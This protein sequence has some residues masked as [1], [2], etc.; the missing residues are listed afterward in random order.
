MSQGANTRI[1]TQCKIP[2]FAYLRSFFAI[3]ALKWPFWGPPGSIWRRGETMDYSN[4]DKLQFFRHLL[5]SRNMEK[6]ISD[7][8]LQMGE[9]LSKLFAEKPVEVQVSRRAES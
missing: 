6:P 4:V 8:V 7:V 5:S 3:F 9:G 1:L 2:T